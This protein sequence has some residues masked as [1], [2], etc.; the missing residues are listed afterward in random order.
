MV[1]LN[2]TNE[3]LRDRSERIVMEMTGLS[4][5]GARRLLQ[6]ANG[7]VKAAVVMRFRNVDLRR[8]CE[9]LDECDRSLRKAME[10]AE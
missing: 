2:A 4:R 5:A 10:A 6:R 3:K 8:A 9:I 1:D 7:K